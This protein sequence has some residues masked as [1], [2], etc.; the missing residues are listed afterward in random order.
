MLMEKSDTGV[1]DAQ[2]KQKWEMWD[3]FW[4]DTN[5]QEWEEWL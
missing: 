3:R 5:V 1:S 4:G 2:R